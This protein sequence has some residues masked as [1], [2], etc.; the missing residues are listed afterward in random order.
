MAKHMAGR[1]QRPYSGRDRES[2]TETP[3]PAPKPR[4][5]EEPE[6]TP[7]SLNFSHKPSEKADRIPS[8]LHDLHFAPQQPSV[9]EEPKAQEPKTQEPTRVMPAQDKTVIYDVPQEQKREPAPAPAPRN[10]TPAPQDYDPAD[11]EEYEEY[12]KYDDEDGQNNG[13]Y[14]DDYDDYDDAPRKK[15]SPVVPVVIVMLVLA[16]G[17][18]AYI[19]YSLGA[20]GKILPQL[21]A[22]PTPVPTAEP[23]ATP[24]P[25]PTPTPEPTA[26]P[27]PTPPPIYDDGT[28]G[29]MS[30]G[31]LMYNNK[32]FELFYGSDDMAT[33]YAEMLNG[34]AEQLTNIK[35]YSMVIP[36]HSEF[37][38][39]E[40]VRDYYGE[41]SQR[42]NT[43]AIYNA[44]SDKVTA[45]DIYDALNLHNDENIYFNT[46]THWAPLGAFYAYEKFCDVAGV[47][48][49]TLDSFTKTTSEFTGYLAY[50][51]GEDVL[52]NNPDTLDLYDP[53]YNYT[54]E[55]SYDGQ[56]FEEADAMNSHDESM[57]YSM[58]MHG[59]MGCVRVKNTDLSTG[60]KLL[61]VKDSYG[62]A[63]G[64]FLAASFDEV[65]VV[66]FR[67][68]EGDLPSYC[69][70]NGITDVLFAN[71]EMAANT[72]Q[73]HDSIR[74]MFN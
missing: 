70:E 22:T 42:E 3:A 5:T 10:Q 14:E 19:A 9:S 7:E 34:F 67:Y 13:D 26:T 31:I 48:P 16:I 2:R 6:F 68:F 27:E 24:E 72:A 1:N 28:E 60:R 64:P 55:I 49:V 41:V 17:I 46:D 35:T 29:Y 51:T 32:G 21:S 43:T 11:Y 50:A 33:A 20:F 69:A 44:L 23:T 59:D 47:T 62:N 66:D 45:V 65:H 18:L 15:R 74:S 37:G 39:P 58:Y 36:N 30:S 8:S 52:Y 71:N 61:V 56:Y 63:M 38:V 54:C 12:I 40:R 53:K 73:H 4:Q 25:T 57:G